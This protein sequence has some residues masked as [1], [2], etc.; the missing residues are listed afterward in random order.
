MAFWRLIL[1]I[2]QVDDHIDKPR[3]SFLAKELLFEY[4]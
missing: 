4:V 2:E 1:E 3:G